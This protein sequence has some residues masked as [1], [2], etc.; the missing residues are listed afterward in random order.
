VI[1]N[2]PMLHWGNTG[3]EFH[4]HMANFSRAATTYTHCENLKP[5]PYT[6]RTRF[7]AR[8]TFLKMSWKFNIHMYIHT[9]TCFIN[10]P[11]N[12]SSCWIWHKSFNIINIQNSHLKVYFLGLGDWPLHP[13]QCRAI[14]LVYIWTCRLCVY[15]IYSNIHFYTIYLFI[16]L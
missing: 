12:H 4:I 3:H 7:Y 15:C 6:G 16:F 9:Y 5:C 10:P 14:Q 8:V 2:I 1:Q 13:I 11:Y